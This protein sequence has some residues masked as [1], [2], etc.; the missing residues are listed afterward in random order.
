MNKLPISSFPP[1]SESQNQA[2]NF[3]GSY[4]D[5][6]EK[7]IISFSNFILKNFVFEQRRLRNL[8][9][10][11]TKKGIDIG[12][13]ISELRQEKENERL[14][15]LDFGLILPQE[16]S[17]ICASIYRPDL[18]EK[19]EE[20]F[21]RKKS[22]IFEVEEEGGKRKEKEKEKN[23]EKFKEKKSEKEKNREENIGKSK[24]KNEEKRRKEKKI[25]GKNSK[26]LKE[27]VLQYIKE[28]G[29]DI[30]DISQNENQINNVDE[31]N[32]KKEENIS[33][34]FKGLNMNNNYEKELNQKIENNGD[35]IEFN[36]DKNNNNES[37]ENIENKIKE[38]NEKIQNAVNVS[39]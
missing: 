27:H 10:L 37:G 32:L 15:G 1:P 36:L 4:I 30:E 13:L 17:D 3:L 29:E 7:H 11:T 20:M 31:N 18:I 33:D 39:K 2:L 35:Y 38:L 28:N 14:E 12:T 21:N 24:G 6:L 23:K 26:N 34:L 5:D 16:I 19:L 9:Q 25:K 22:S 8:A